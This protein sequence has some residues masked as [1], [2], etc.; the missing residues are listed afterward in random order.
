[1]L[2]ASALSSLIPHHYQSLE[3]C[4][5]VNLRR[6]LPG[7]L[8]DTEGMGVFIDA[9]SQYYTGSA[10][11]SFTWAEARRSKAMINAYLQTG[12]QKVNVAKLGM[13]SDMPEFFLGKVGKE[14]GS[15]FDVSNLGG[16]AD[17][18]G[19][20]W[21]MGKMV[22]SRSDFVTGSAFSTGAV[23]GPDGCLVFGFVWQDGVVEEELMMGVIEKVR[24]EIEGLAREKSAVINE[25]SS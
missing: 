1:M 23:T 18:E 25:L 19:G 5:L 12:S 20:N 16:L 8:I 9:F 24:C 13:V 10:L 6:W 7:S 21:R 15:S 22:F 4:I 11:S 3:A 2:L 14:R 17:G